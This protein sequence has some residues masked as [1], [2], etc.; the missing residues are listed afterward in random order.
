MKTSWRRHRPY[1]IAN[2][3]FRVVA[4]A[5]FCLGL[6]YAVERTVPTAPSC[7][8]AQAA[9]LTRLIRYEALFHVAPPVA[10]LIAGVVLGSWLA[11]AVLRYHRSARTA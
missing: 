9:C 6:L 1:A 11:R 5:G 4:V 8:V 3:T 7:D 2:L 10:G